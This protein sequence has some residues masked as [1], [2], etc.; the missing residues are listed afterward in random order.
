MI[1]GFKVLSVGV[2]YL[3]ASMIIIFFLKIIGGTH[4]SSNFEGVVYPWG[5]PCLVFMVEMS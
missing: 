3:L 1:G 2:Y 4:K 5:K